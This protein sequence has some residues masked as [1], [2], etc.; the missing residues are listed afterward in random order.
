M[1]RGPFHHVI[2]FMSIYHGGHLDFCLNPAKK[3]ETIL[4]LRGNGF[5]GFLMG[6]RFMQSS[7]PELACK[8]FIAELRKELQIEKPKGAC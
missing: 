1:Y 5:K 7:R 6:E 3:I 4:K 2:W 8:N